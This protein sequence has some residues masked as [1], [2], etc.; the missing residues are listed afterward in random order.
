MPPGRPPRRPRPPRRGRQQRA[1]PPGRLIR[2]I[3]PGFRTASRIG[4]GVAVAPSPWGRF[5]G[6]SPSRSMR[7]VVRSTPMYVLPVHTL[8]LPDAEQP[9]RRPFSVSA[10]SGKSQGDTWSA[11]FAV[12]LHVVRAH[13][14]DLRP[15]RPIVGVRVAEGAGLGRAAGGVVLRIEVEHDRRPT[16]GRE[17]HLVAGLVK[18]REIGRGLAFGDHGRGLH[19]RVIESSRIV[20]ADAPGR[21]GARVRRRPW[22]SGGSPVRGR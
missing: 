10:R 5:F 4:L 14:E 9:G 19:S 11:N 6:S 7:T 1:H 2:P 13:A 8:L 20:C 18:E 3:S 22:P 12:R 15:G 21:R 16:Q 17:R